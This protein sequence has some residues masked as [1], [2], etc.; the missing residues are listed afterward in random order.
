MEDDK[1]VLLVVIVSPRIMLDEMNSENLPT[2]T[3]LGS[4]SGTT[5]RS[6]LGRYAALST[7]GSRKADLP[8]IAGGYLL[9]DSKNEAS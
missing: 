9:N 5:L 4:A 1:E 8:G 7:Y 6:Y 2:P 3:R